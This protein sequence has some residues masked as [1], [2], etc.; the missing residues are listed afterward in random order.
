[1][2]MT[3]GV[4]DVGCARPLVYLVDD[5]RIVHCSLTFLTGVQK[6]P[7]HCNV[8]VVSARLKLELMP[9]AKSVMQSYG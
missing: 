2:L 8:G 1:M 4:Q 5:G 3:T 6:N 9:S 7:H